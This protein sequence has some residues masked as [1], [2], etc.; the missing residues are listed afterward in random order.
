MPR[1]LLPAA[2]FAS[3]AL[4][5][6]VVGAFAG[7]HLMGGKPH[8]RPDGRPRNPVAAAVRTLTP[9]QQAA[10]RAQ[11]PAFNESFGPKVREARQLSRATMRSFADEPF[12]ADAK[13]A[14]LSQ[15]RALEQEGR[16]EMDRRLVSFA[17]TLPP[18]DRAKFGEA[19]AH[20][21]PGRDRSGN[22]HR[23]ALPDR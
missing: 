16:L 14:A 12:D 4:N 9:D 3:L 8:G 15:A 10:W 2:L 18:A 11:M 7:Q 21:P 5:V 6:F 13:L 23:R 1:W 20:P 19:L 17:A 22:G